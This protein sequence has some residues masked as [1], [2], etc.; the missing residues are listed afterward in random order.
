MRLPIFLLSCVLISLTGCKSLSNLALTNCSP[1]SMKLQSVKELNGVYANK[2]DTMRGSYYHAPY[3]GKKDPYQISI[4]EHLFINIPEE[5]DRIIY[6]ISTPDEQVYVDIKFI[7][8]KRFIMTAFQ[9]DR[10]IFERVVRGK[11]RNGYFYLRPKKFVIPFIPLVFGYYFKKA[12][13]GKCGQRLV[14][15]YRLNYWGF[16][17]AAGGSNKARTTS[18]Y[19]QKLPSKR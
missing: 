10:F 4:L 9:D 16:A 13:I 6:G 3:T 12:R 17:L 11:Y 8:E 19:S 15:D 18:L 1:D 5:A 2:S 7:S 14:I